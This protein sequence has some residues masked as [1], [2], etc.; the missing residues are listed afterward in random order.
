MFELI[1]Q[2]QVKASAEKVF[3]AFTSPAGLNSWWT[4]EAGGRPETGQTCRFYFGPEYDWRATVIHIVHGKELTW[5]MTR[6]MEDWMPTQVGFVLTEEKGACSVRFFHR[7]WPNNGDHFAITNFCWGQLLRGLKNY[8]E[9]GIAVP[10][11]LRN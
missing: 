6:A 1:H 9:N 10:F 11:E 4:L 7:N 5:Q 2:F 3:D 8:V